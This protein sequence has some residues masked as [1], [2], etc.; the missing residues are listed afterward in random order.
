MTHALTPLLLYYYFLGNLA[1][2]EFDGIV[3]VV[4]ELPVLIFGTRN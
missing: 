4:A 2:T 3:T 1:N